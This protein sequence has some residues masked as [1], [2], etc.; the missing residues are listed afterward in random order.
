MRIKNQK[1]NTAIE[2]AIV[3]PLL[4]VLI[5]GI[6]EFSIILYDKS[7]IT[8]AS[9]EGARSGIL[10]IYDSTGNYTPLP[11]GNQASPA[12]NS[13]INGI[14]KVYCSA[15]LINFGAGNLTTT[16][17][18][19]LPLVSGGNRVIKVSYTYNFLLLPN[20]VHNLSGNILLAATTT[21]RME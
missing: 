7:I 10:A 9:R 15:Y 12:D 18:S 13:T 8:N 16:D 2:F 6:I 4:I 3:F 19:T 21:M 11:I 14:V 17:L 5:F 20:F 1:G